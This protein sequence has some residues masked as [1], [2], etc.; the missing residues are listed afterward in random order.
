MRV[1]ETPFQQKSIGSILV[2][3]GVC[4]RSLILSVF[5]LFSS[6]DE[7]FSTSRMQIRA[8]SHVGVSVS[9]NT[10]DCIHH[11]IAFINTANR[12][13]ADVQNSGSSVMLSMKT[14]ESKKALIAV[15][16]G[17]YAVIW[18][19]LFFTHDKGEKSE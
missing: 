6:Y 8:E 2:K 17:A 18:A 15:V 5:L 3:A 11:R 7:S 4:V 16:S 1:F 12:I 10:V 13:D 14:A 9:S 19:F